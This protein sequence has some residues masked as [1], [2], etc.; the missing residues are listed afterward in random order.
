ML[1]YVFRQ[2]RMMRANIGLN[3]RATAG[4]QTQISVLRRRKRHRQAMLI[5]A[6]DKLKVS[7]D[8]WSA[9]TLDFFVVVVSKM[10]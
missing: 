6:R 5:A 3:R 7:V 1:L 4:L 2:F 8:G 10:N 9:A